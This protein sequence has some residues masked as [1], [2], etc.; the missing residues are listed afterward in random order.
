MRYPSPPNSGTNVQSHNQEDV[1]VSVVA[2][3]A[4]PQCVNPL[5]GG[6]GGGG[7]YVGMNSVCTNSWGTAPGVGR[8]GVGMNLISSLPCTSTGAM[9]VVSGGDVGVV[10]NRDVEIRSNESSSHHLCNHFPRHLHFDA[11]Q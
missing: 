9:P 7:I 5:L 1:S 4:D 8:P 6:G 2:F 10:G 3:A 11:T